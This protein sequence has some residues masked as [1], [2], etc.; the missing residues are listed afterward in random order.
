MEFERFFAELTPRLGMARALER[1]LD[2]NL[3]HRFN[4]FD[5][6]RK[7]SDQERVPE[8]LLS[9]IIAD[10]LKH[11]AKH[12]QGTLF[13]QTLLSLEGLKNALQWPDL[14][15]S[16]K[17][18][19]V[20]ERR[21]TDER[22]I[23]ISVEIVS[24][25]EES[26]CLAI[27]NKPYA[28]DLEDQVSAYLDYLREKYGERFLL[29]YLSPTGEGPSE[30]SIPKMELDE[31]KGRF[32]IMP[33]CAG[34][35]EQADG[36]RDFR[37][38]RTLADWLGECRK[39]CEVDR[40]CWFLRDFETFC[41]R[42]FGGQ[43]VTTNR[44]KEE[45]LK[46]VFSGQSNLET[47]LAVSE[48]W[49]DVKARVCES[50]LERLCARIM[51]AVKEHRQLNEFADDVDIYKNYGSE[52]YDSNVWLF[53]KC[54]TQYQ[55]GQQPDGRTSIALQNAKKGPN[56]WGIGVRSPLS[57]EKML[58]QDLERRK[59]LDTYLGRELGC[60]HDYP[61]WP[62]WMVLTDKEKTNWN[63]LVLDLYKESNQKVDEIMSYFVGK[64]IEIAEIAIPIINDIEAEQKS[65]P[66]AIPPTNHE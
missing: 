33:Y 4:V 53:R 66:Q 25:N 49:P 22:R 61:Y 34:Q 60:D 56:E 45:F 20:E 63:V 24:A 50:F 65:P 46:F 30:E 32:A 35:E 55:G 48:Y 42:Q 15:G 57:R 9:R 44:E 12:G 1:E 40:L 26:C 64:F 13:L 10:L 5:Y 3:A 16:Q 29:I 14:D 2:R 8:L 27:E 6:L 41:R 19:V 51:T 52:A 21:I 38:P 28:D 7:T 59:K 17:I 58:S 62:W 31:W 54:W 18:S 39:N 23:D 43:V 47:A 11:E 36:F 37:I